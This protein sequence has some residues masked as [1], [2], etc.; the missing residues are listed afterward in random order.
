MRNAG[1][2]NED[3]MKRTP[4]TRTK[5]RTIYNEKYVS[6][7]VHVTADEARAVLDTASC[8][9]AV[10][11]GEIE[12][13]SFENQRRLVV[14]MRFEQILKP[15]QPSDA[16]DPNVDSRTGMPSTRVKS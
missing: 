2:S 13:P 1:G 9:Y 12:I 16:V 14:V 4:Y 5:T 11:Q 10:E 7:A 15:A 3:H 8:I 6:R